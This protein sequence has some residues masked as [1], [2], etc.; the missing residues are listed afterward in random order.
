MEALYQPEVPIQGEG[1]GMKCLVCGREAISDLCKYH[2]AAKEGV[3]SAYGLWVKAY[4][5]MGWKTYLDRVI[6]NSQSGQWA[7][8]VAKLLEGHLDDK[9]TD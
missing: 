9:R 8:E 7:K 3:E 1:R 4:G 2:Q 6:T 5:S